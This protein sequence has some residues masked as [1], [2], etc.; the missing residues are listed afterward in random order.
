MLAEKG[1]SG[2]AVLDNNGN[3]VDTLSIRDLREI[4]CNIQYYNY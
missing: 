2:C 3:L 4:V 1:I